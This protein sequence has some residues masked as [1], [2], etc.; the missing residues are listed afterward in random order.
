MKYQSFQQKRISRQY[1]SK[2]SAVLLIAL[3]IVSVK[4]IAPISYYDATTYEN[5]TELKPAVV[6]LYETFKND[7]IDKA[8]IQEVRLRMAQVYEYEKGKGESNE[9]TRIQVKKIWDMFEGHVKDRVE[10]GKWM[11]AHF[12]NNKRN[13]EDAFDIAIQTERLKN[14]NE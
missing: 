2:I 12:E 1:W 5:L 11:E 3:L 9:P 13:L 7:N 14:K 6:F 4:C 8:H 10:T